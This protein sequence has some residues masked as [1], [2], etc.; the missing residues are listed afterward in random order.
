LSI[1]VP[2]AVRCVAGSLSPVAG[3]QGAPIP[4]IIAN[5]RSF[6]LSRFYFASLPALPDRPSQAICE[7]TNPAW[8]KNRIE[9]WLSIGILD[10]ARGGFGVRFPPD[11]IGAREIHVIMDMFLSPFSNLN[12]SGGDERPAIGTYDFE[13]ANYDLADSRFIGTE[14][15]RWR[16][17][18]ARW[19]DEDAEGRRD[20]DILLI[21]VLAGLA[22]TAGYDAVSRFIEG[23]T[24]S[25]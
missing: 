20:L 22:V 17:I 15:G 14:L 16:H 18:D 24:N 2:S 4:I 23:K 9:R 19:Y 13:Q 21:G 1:L 5:P 8:H 10:G 6:G 3:L 12:I 25:G 11:K 7:I